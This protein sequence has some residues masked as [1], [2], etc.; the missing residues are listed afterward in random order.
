MNQNR[1]LM[2]PLK[3]KII[4]KTFLRYPNEIFAFQ[5]SNI[6]IHKN[7]STELVMIVFGG[8]LYLGF[9]CIIGESEKKKSKV[10]N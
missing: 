8:F 1:M 3:L 9:D 4:F 5:I 10:F 7:H 2:L 6:H